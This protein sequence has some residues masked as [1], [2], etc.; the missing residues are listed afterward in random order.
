[1][2]LYC[3][4]NYK[5]AANKEPAYLSLVLSELINEATLIANFNIPGRHRINSVIRP[6]LSANFSTGTSTALSIET[7]RFANGTFF[8]PINS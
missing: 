1:M 3:R 7:N 4:P 2:H 6:E 8:S 5:L